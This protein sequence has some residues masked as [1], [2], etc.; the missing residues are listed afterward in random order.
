MARY[1]I[2]AYPDMYGGLH[3]MYNYELTDDI[4]Y[5]SALEWGHELA[6]ETV[7]QF[8]RNDEIYSREDYMHDNYDG[9][10]WNDCYEEDYW[11]AFNEVM[12]EQADFYIWPLKEGVT[13]KDYIKWQKENMDPKDF[14]DRFC[15]VL[16]EKD[17]I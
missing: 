5:E 15:R 4:D 7:E 10:E 3:G 8:L 16:T 13:E 17:C 2:Y 12:D 1:F 9:A 14:I 6:H 11:D